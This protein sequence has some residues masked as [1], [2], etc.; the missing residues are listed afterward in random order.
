M[1]M[2]QLDRYI[3]RQV[4]ATT[5][6]SLLV[7]LALESFFSFMGE[8]DRIGEGSY[9][10]LD[11]AQY[12]LLRL[13]QVAVERMPMALLLGGLLGMGAL[14]AG[15]ELIA[16]RAAAWSILRIVASTL[17]CGVLV[18]VVTAVLAEFVVP[19]MNHL[20]ESERAEARG[21]NL[22]I[23]GGR[24]FWVRDAAFL[25][26]IREVLP[27]GDLANLKLYTIDA[28]RRL[29]TVA[30]A[31]T[32]VFGPQGWRLLDLI[33]DDLRSDTVRRTLQAERRWDSAI[34]PRLLEVL[35]L[36]PEQM[37]ARDLRVYSAYLARNGL[38]ARSYRLALWEKLIAPFS[39]LVMLF[40][41]MP[42]VFGPLRSSAAGQRL[43]VGVMV[44]LLFY[45]STTT[46]SSLG[47]AYSLPPLLATAMGPMVFFLVALMALTR[48]R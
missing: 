35:V 44:G 22:S 19:S 5:L 16:M 26:Q 4:L 36:K 23:R 30:T 48:M 20:A 6:V 18:V 24:G 10:P 39:N 33:E 43:F 29:S 34:S 46:L 27:S 38:D 32:A 42:F 7:L 40:V 8:I 37:S 47:L 11:I 31:R 12:V 2:T 28:G 14:A 17:S 25:I 15:S 41:A 1:I 21:R 9:G 13:P 45:L 3:F